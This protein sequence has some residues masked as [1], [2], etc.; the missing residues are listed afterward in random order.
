MGRGRSINFA[1]H[2]L[3]QGDRDDLP[4]VTVCAGR[5]CRPG[6]WDVNGFAWN[7]VGMGAWDCFFNI[8]TP[9][10]CSGGKFARE[11]SV[12]AAG[13]VPFGRVLG[14]GA[15][16]FR[17][18][19]YADRLIAGGVGVSNAEAAVA[20]AMSSMRGLL[21]EGAPFWGRL[22]VDGVLLEYR[23]FPLPG[24]QVNVGTIFPVMP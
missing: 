2:L 12:Y 13:I 20:G 18:A 15:T 22:T 4:N 16:I 10:A 6:F 8:G 17:T 14:E 11:G 1:F 24:G 21:S 23:A 5:G 19:H 9:Y 7:A 3:P